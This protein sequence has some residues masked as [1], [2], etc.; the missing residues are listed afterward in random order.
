MIKNNIVQLI[1]RRFFLKYSFG[2]KIRDLLYPMYRRLF[3]PSMIESVLSAEAHTKDTRHYEMVWCTENLG[4][5]QIVNGL[6]S[7]VEDPI[8]IGGTRFAICNEKISLDIARMNGKNLS[9]LYTDYYLQEEL[10][11]NVQFDPTINTIEVKSSAPRIKLYGNW[12]STLH[13]SSEN[14]MHFMAEC[15]PRLSS[16]VKN[17]AGM[18]MGIL[19]DQSIPI[20]AFE[21]IKI[22]APDQPKLGI[23]SSV[24]VQVEKLLTPVQEKL[25]CS[26]SW[27]RPNSLGKTGFFDFDAEALL[28]VRRKVL[29]HFAI[30]PQLKNKVYINR[31]STF[32]YLVNQKEV[33]NF[34]R[35]HKF[36]LL[37]PGDLSLQQQVQAFSE[38]SILVAQAGAALANMIF[39]PKGAK[40]IC[41][42]ADSVWTN[43]SY[44][45]DYAEIFGI[46]FVFLKGH[47]QHPDKYNDSKVCSVHHPLNSDF[48]VSIEK[49]A[50]TLTAMAT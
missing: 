37:T 32:R 4:N 25:T 47:I 21:V 12:L 36:N 26:A 3:R 6:I 27:P 30:I 13:S 35:D 9:K 20:S 15:A 24:A 48:K 31:K 28:D 42:N 19:Y 1:Y 10:I 22:I 39:M 29:E 40:V 2:P 34:L 7:V 5:N 23:S 50:N 41:I 43:S 44:F 38:I 8:V 16:A 14:W 11:S 45:H 49:L 17:A 46:D 33:S 18:P